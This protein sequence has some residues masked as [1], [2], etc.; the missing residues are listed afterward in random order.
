MLSQRAACVAAAILMSMQGLALA[1]APKAAPSPAQAG[2][3]VLLDNPSVRVVEVLVRPGSNLP[4]AMRP[5]RLMYML[6]DASLVFQEDGKPSY[7][8]IFKAGE[9]VWIPAQARV[10]ENSSGR[11]VRALIVDIRQAPAARAKARAGTK[12]TTKRR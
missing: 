8:M 1:Q 2:S 3:K 12:R 6:T 7:E 4:D 9:A 11:D 5:G 10:A